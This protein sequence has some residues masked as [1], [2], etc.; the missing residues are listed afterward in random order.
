MR[1]VKGVSVEVEVE[2]T[3]GLFSISVVGLADTAVKEARERVRAALRAAGVNIRGRVSI[4]LAPAD[5]PKEGALL[6]LPIAV[7][8]LAREA[9]ATRC[10]LNSSLKLACNKR[11]NDSYE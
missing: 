4:N 10:A 2:I 8:R 3:G 11:K 5:V 9:G 1:G 6:D 7:A